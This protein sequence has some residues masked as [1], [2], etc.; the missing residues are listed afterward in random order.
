MNGPPKVEPNA[1]Q[2]GQQPAHGPYYMTGARG[3]QET[4]YA[5][6]LQTVRK[7][8]RLTTQACFFLYLFNC[9]MMSAKQK[10]LLNLCVYKALRL[11]LFFG[12]MT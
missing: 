2:I 3:R 1:L 8:L 11:K 10:I 4:V 6:E 5:L 9:T 12:L 7:H